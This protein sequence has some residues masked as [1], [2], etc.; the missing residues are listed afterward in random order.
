MMCVLPMLLITVACS[1]GGSGKLDIDGVTQQL[2]TPT[3]LRIESE[4]FKWNPVENASQ[5]MVKVNSYEYYATN[6]EFT[7][8]LAAGDYDLSVRAVGD[9]ILFKS[10]AFSAPITYKSFGQPGGSTSSQ[11]GLFG[12]FDDLS[13]YESYLGY[14]FDVIQSNEF[15]SKTVK[16][17]NSIFNHEKLLNQRLLKVVE[18][19]SSINSYSGYTMD[20]LLQSWNA[21]V[22][23]DVGWGK[24][25][26]GGSVSVATKYQGSSSRAESQFFYGMDIVNQNYYLVL[27]S[28]IDTYREILSAAFTRDLYN[29]KV[30]PAQLFDRY[31]THF[32]TSAVMGGKISSHYHMTS[33]TVSSFHEVR[34]SVDTEVRYL[35]GKTNVSV[36]TGYRQQAASQNIQ[37]TNSIDVIGGGNFGILSD[38][39]IGVNYKD[40]EASLNERPALMGLKDASTLWQIWDLID[41]DQ[42]TDEI[43]ACVDDNDQEYLGTRREQLE[44]YFLRY[45]LE[46]YNDL[47]AQFDIRPIKAPSSI[48][49]IRVNG[50]EADHSGLFTV[51]AGSAAQITFAVEPEDALGYQVNYHLTTTEY[52][53]LGEKGNLQIHADAPNNAI[54]EVTIGAG[55]VRDV[56]RIRI[57]RSYSVFFEVNGGSLISPYTDVNDGA[58]IS[59]PTNPSRKHYVFDAWYSTPTFATGSE[60]NFLNMPITKDTTLYA[61]WDVVHYPITFNSNGGTVITQQITTNISDDF[62]VDRPTNPTRTG[63]T[64]AGWW[65]MQ[66]DGKEEVQFDFNNGMADFALTLNA[67]WKVNFYTT[68]FD[69]NGG[70][71][72]DEQILLFGSKLNEVAVPNPSKPGTFFAGW[73]LDAGLTQRVILSNFTVMCDATLYAKYNNNVVFLTFSTGGGEPIS[74]QALANGEMGVDVKPVREGYTFQGWFKEAEHINPYVFANEAVTIDT[75]I[76]AKWAINSYRITFADTGTSVIS[77]IVENFGTAVTLPTGLIRIGYTFAGWLDE[78][79]NDYILETMPAQNVALSGKWTPIPYTSR[80]MFIQ[81][82]G[83]SPVI[84]LAGANNNVIVDFS[85]ENAISNLNMTITNS[86][87]YIKFIG[88]FDRNITFT[89]MSI[90]VDGNRNI[91]LT[92]E[93]ENFGYT[94]GENNSA[95]VSAS[96]LADIIVMSRGTNS[97]TG[98]HGR[99]GTTATAGLVGAAA[100]RTNGGISVRGT[101]ILTITGGRGGDGGTGTSY[102]R[103]QN[104]DKANGSNGGV[105]GVGGNGGDAIAA[106]AFSFDNSNTFLLNINGGRAGDGGN[107]G[108]GEGTKGPKYAQ[109][110]H[111][112]AGGGGGIG[113]T[114]ISLAFGLQL[115]IA[116]SNNIKITGGDGGRGGNGGH[117]GTTG[118]GA[119]DYA[120]NAGNGGIGG[121]G[122]V[123][124][125]GIHFAQANP[126]VIYSGQQQ[127]AIIGGNGGNGGNGGDGGNARNTNFGNGW[128]GRGGQVGNG[129]NGGAGVRVLSSTVFDTLTSITRSIGGT[130]GQTY[131]ANG[132]GTGQKPNPQN[133]DG[134]VNGDPGA[135]VLK[136]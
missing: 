60:F 96:T 53:T 92:I 41:V 77:A 58:T 112:G 55:S 122:G 21:S 29:S 18:N 8:S 123:G 63:H 132:T 106:R 67:R 113:G 97:I 6:N 125:F 68:M 121:S 133:H 83:A 54:I 73:F 48:A 24:K 117:G 104:A 126:N 72:I 42:D 35:I 118:C 100:I 130:R 31:G 110:G 4:M 45:G 38:H 87:S 47:M 131:G 7:L 65:Y 36:E 135:T 99:M 40:W 1:G 19:R 16:I 78:N 32:I 86:I 91:P 85:G 136:S 105:G 44:N 90:T 98:G 52:A 33:E 81:A 10:S 61:K 70:T 75:T 115:T 39:D 119:S 57:K 34:A 120:D 84:T 111:G 114:G 37:V 129:G 11:S 3:S 107:G 76:Y 62:R 56:V 71:N 108:N 82:F 74:K 23:V 5:Y 66:P 88:A 134:R 79:G 109:S 46:A 80:S 13:K 27:Q 12:S 9:N 51:N 59:K 93:F 101:G 25:K 89:N 69:T 103:T 102:N 128:N 94:A 2:T 64:F 124:G 95:L 116:N 26:I 14:G 50:Q 15:S 43:Y 20:E 30:S 22:N 127:L 17:S 28:D 49:K